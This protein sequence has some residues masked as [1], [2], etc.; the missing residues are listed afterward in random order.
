MKSHNSNNCILCETQKYPSIWSNK[1]F[2]VLL[3]ND[4]NYPGYCRVDLIN[5]VEEMTDLDDE[6]R[7][8]FM[9]VIFKIEKLIMEYLKPDKMNLASL[10]NVTPHL[11][12]HIIPRYLNDNH[13]PES[14]WSKQNKYDAKEFS[15]SEEIK[16]ISFIKNKLNQ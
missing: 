13:F 3:I 12:W 16:F 5:H 1:L 9:G 15:V 11:H 2:R 6:T 10:G 14:I 4:H 8:K 7:N